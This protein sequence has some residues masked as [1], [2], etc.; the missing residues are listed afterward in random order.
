MRY[1]L[2][3]LLSFFI[4][5]PWTLAANAATPLPATAEHAP[6]SPVA[7]DTINLNTADAKILSKSIKGI[8]SKRAQAVVSYR[9]THG[10][11]KSVLDLGE[12][13]GI[14]KRFVEHHQEEI[15]RR[16]SIR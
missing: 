8:G 13:P 15:E 10:S 12:V 3:S 5:S 4:F 6:A 2:I 1:M 7:T 9:E 11:F 14:G 16:F